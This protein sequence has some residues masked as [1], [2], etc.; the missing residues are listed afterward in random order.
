MVES[1]VN[2]QRV[3]QPQPAPLAVVEV[4]RDDTRCRCVALRHPFAAH[5]NNRFKIS[6]AAL[7][8]E[9]LTDKLVAILDL[10]L[11]IP[12]P[13]VLRVGVLQGHLTLTDVVR[14]T[15]T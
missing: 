2:A 7:L 14:A 5:D 4:V 9:S 15:Y 1:G 12:D 11:Y 13:N 8:L 10:Y 6:K 3:S